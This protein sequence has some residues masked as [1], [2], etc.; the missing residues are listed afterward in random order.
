MGEQRYAGL[1]FGDISAIN[2]RNRDLGV[3][4]HLLEREDWHPRLLFGTDYPLPGI[5]PLV[6]RQLARESSST[7]PRCRCW[8]PPRAQSPA[9]RLRSQAPPALGTSA[10]CPRR[11][12]NTPLL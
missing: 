5:L 8:K 7:R 12:R 1:L 6:S 11:L 9:L 10:L 3:I 2:L 4:R